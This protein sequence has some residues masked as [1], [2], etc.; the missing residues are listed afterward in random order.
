MEVT[1]LP[2]QWLL[3]T[4]SPTEKRPLRETQQLPPFSA[5]KKMGGTVCI[6]L[7]TH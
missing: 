5:R 7:R 4:L 3:R 2:G 1:P 6:P